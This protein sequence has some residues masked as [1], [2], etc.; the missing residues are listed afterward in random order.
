MDTFFRKV[1]CMVVSKKLY[2]ACVAAG[3]FQG[4]CFGFVQLIVFLLHKLIGSIA[5]VSYPL[6]FLNGFIIAS[7]FYFILTRL[8]RDL[9]LKKPHALCHGVFLFLIVLFT[10][11]FWFILI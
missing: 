6:H 2:F 4:F 5:F 7:S 8:L 10:F 11:L 9:F 3:L 1:F